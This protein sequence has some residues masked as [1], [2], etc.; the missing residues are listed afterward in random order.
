MIG[1]YVTKPERKITS[2]SCGAR[3]ASRRDWTGLFRMA[4]RKTCW[5]TSCLLASKAS[6]WKFDI[7]QTSAQSLVV[8]SRNNIFIHAVIYFMQF[9]GKFSDTAFPR[10]SA[11]NR[12]HLNLWSRRCDEGN[13]TDRYQQS[14]M[15]ECC[16]CKVVKICRRSKK[17][18]FLAR[19][20]SL[21]LS[22][23]RRVDENKEINQINSWIDRFSIVSLA[24]L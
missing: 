14:A 12:I 9:G 3:N 24:L 2:I 11:F 8:G 17:F 16:V 5:Q 19:R 20:H 15:P 13:L 10:R 7:Q 21:T 1:V 23:E 22:H 6:E 18:S 4:E